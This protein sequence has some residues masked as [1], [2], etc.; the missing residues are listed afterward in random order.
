[1]GGW[2]PSLK[3]MHKR[4]LLLFSF[5]KKS[6]LLDY[7]HVLATSIVLKHVCQENQLT[8][9]GETCTGLTEG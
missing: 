2:V 6:S 7:L 9:Q 1:M 3:K 4:R 5:Q 8:R